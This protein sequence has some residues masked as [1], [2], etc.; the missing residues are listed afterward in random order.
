[1]LSKFSLQ[2][3]KNILPERKK[4]D[5]KTAGGKC[6][7]IAGSRGMFGAAVLAATAAARTG[8]GYVI[9]MT[10]QKKFSSVKHPDF[11]LVDYK[12]QK[13]A[14]LKFNA[15]AIGPGLGQSAHTLKI[16]KQLIKLNVTNVV[17]DA[18]ALNLCAKHQ[19]YPL[20]SSWVATPHEGEL[21]RL[22]KV[23]SSSIKKNRI[24]SAQKAVKKLGCTVVLKGNQTVVATTK[25]TFIV[26]SGN[27]A[28][29]K[30]G[31]GDVLTGIIAALLSQ[32]LKPVDAACLGVFI[33]GWLADQWIKNKKDH[34]SLM[35]SD[36]L[37]LLPEALYQIRNFRK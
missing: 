27:P 31:T 12:K 5:N 13:L 11:L 3:A 7:I 35:A 15:V 37:A 36:L 20:P 17:I 29:A 21:S 1:M 14:D 30:A 22:L 8:A 18:D 2:N 16:L 26:N 32:D 6:L 33:H 34:L 28:L 9:L 24:Q 10:D 19:L 4:T 23:S 25:K